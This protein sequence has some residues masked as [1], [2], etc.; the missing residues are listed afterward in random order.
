MILYKLDGYNPV[1]KNYISP[2]SGQAAPLPSQP[3]VVADAPPQNYSE[4]DSADKWANYGENAMD[5]VIGLSDYLSLR[6]QIYTRIEA[7]AGEDYADWDDLSAEEKQAALI[8]SN[9]RIVNTR[10][11]A[12]YATECGGMNVA[13]DYIN[14]YLN[15]AYLAREERYYNAF[16]IFGYTYMGKEQGLKAENYARKDFLDSIYV[17]RGVMFKSVD[18]IDGLGDWIQGIN[19]YSVTGLKPRIVA[20]EFTLLYG[21]TVDVF[22]DTLV[23]ILDDGI[24]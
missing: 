22:C 20:G 1:T 17:E 2:S 14:K 13:T 7:I 16:T 9:I 12:F 10:G 5:S 6:Y 8:W 19:G 23:G 15:Q 24:Y 4:F 11:I 21:M 3:F 18:D